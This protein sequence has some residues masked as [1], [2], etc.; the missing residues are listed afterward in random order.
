MAAGSELLQLWRD[1]PTHKRVWAIAL[2]MILSNISVPLV[3]LVDTAVIG[4]LDG[5]HFLGGV[6]VGS[7]LFTFILW[8]AGF[9]RMGTTGFAAQ[10]CGAEDGAA[11]RRVLLQP[12]W[13]ALLISLL[14]WLFQTPLLNLGLHLLDSSQALLDQARLYVGI[15]LYSLPAALAN[16]VLIGWFIG[17]QN[18]RAPFI[19]LLAVNLCNVALDLLLVVGLEWGV[20]GAAWATVISDYLGLLLGLAL[21][22]PILRRY[23]G[24]TDWLR[25]LLLRGAAPLIRV[26]RDILIRTLALESVFYLLVVQGARLGDEVVAANAVLL[27]F[28]LLTSHGLDGLAH[29]LEALGGHALGRQDKQALRKVLVVSTVWSLVLSCSFVLAF[30]LGGDAII[31]LLTDLPEVRQQAG[32]YLPWMAVMPLAAVW[33]YLLDGL[34]IGASR[35]RAMRNAMLAALLLYLPLAWSL[36]GLGNHGVWLGFLCFMLLRSLL[37]GGW[38]VHLWRADR[39]MAR[40]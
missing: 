33:S 11:L 18:S 23:P 20:A 1:T 5:A 32:T 16:F 36:Q 6:A 34:F 22:Q 31:G 3:G 37:L 14:V 7:T 9:L 17:A 15:R 40:R 27:N 12:L 21:L 8:A 28:L 29:A 2:P 26:N 30:L 4:H 24:Q 39:W 38:F 10:A 35:A 13:L 25:A 19:L